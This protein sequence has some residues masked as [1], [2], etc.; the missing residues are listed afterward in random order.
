MKLRTIL[1]CVALASSCSRPSTTA[2]AGPTKAAPTAT[3]AP[4]R[5][6][7]IMAEVGRRF[8]RAGHA[9]VA[10]RWEFAGYDLGEIEELFE[11]DL[12][13]A[14]M[15]EDVK[16]DLRSIAQAFAN[17]HPGELKHAIRA[18][19]R[20]AFEAAFA[21]TAATCNA[22][23]RAAGKAFIEVPSVVGRAVPQLTDAAVP[24]PPATRPGGR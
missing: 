3:G 14:L 16:V 15:P 24:A 6:G 4:K 13:G 20:A 8:E 17:T 9:V 21:R 11:D 12:P 22:C 2:S 18:R 10:A 23:H 7:D 1:G 19:D 5:Y